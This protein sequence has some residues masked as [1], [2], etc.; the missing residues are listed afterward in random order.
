MRSLRIVLGMSILFFMFS[1]GVSAQV[2]EVTSYGENQEEACEI[3]SGQLAKSISV[4]VTAESESELNTS[5]DSYSQEFR[6]YVLS[7]SEIPLYGVEF[8]TKN[9]G[10]ETECIA[11]ID[12]KKSGEVYVARLNQ[13]IDDIRAVTEGKKL[14]DLPLQILFHLQNQIEQ[15]QKIQIVAISFQVDNIPII[16]VSLSEIR[17]AVV[18]RSDIISSL[19]D[20]TLLVN[21]FFE[22]KAQNIFVYPPLYESN[23][24]ITSFA[25]TIR[26]L[27]TSQVNSTENLTESEALIRGSYR[28]VKDDIELNLRLID[29]NNIN[30][31][32]ITVRISP[33]VFEDYDW[34]PKTNSL[35]QLIKDGVVVTS[36][37]YVELSTNKGGTDLWFNE[38]EEVNLLVR[39][40]QAAYVYF[41]GHNTTTEEPFS[42]LLPIGNG[43][44]KRDMILYISADNANRWVS[45][46]E[47]EI[48]P[49]FGVERLQAV[50]STKDLLD[51]L[52]EYYWN[53]DGYPVIGK[54]PNAV[55]VATRG[56]VRKKKTEASTAETYLNFTTLEE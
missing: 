2:I 28:K 38:G 40:N 6:N 16:P 55:V 17:K 15:S 3:A 44:G 1:L 45:L 9:R 5:L 19:N 12:P 46:G 23:S 11:S 7:R 26:N 25:K 56:L 53:D 32:G 18:E 42:Y 39:T 10:N 35:D 8:I 41:I 20:L 52:P 43:D 4:Q 29:S 24:E 14:S 48:V 30:I 21:K 47:Y 34:E 36:D 27:I 22:G 49:P 51:V 31:A 13:Q 50:A 37:F 54:D 33:K